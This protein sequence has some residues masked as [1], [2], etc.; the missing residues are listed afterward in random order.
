MALLPVPEHV[1]ALE[2]ER[3]RF[4]LDRRGFLVAQRRHGVGQ[5]PSKTE[6][7]KCLGR[8]AGIGSIMTR[9]ENRGQATGNG[10]LAG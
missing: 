9:T 10:G 5:L 1:T 6:S 8:R 2:Q 3:N 7:S 4:A